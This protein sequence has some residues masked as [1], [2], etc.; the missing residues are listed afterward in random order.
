M[1]SKDKSEIGINLAI[2]MDAIL[3]QDSIP[4]D[5]ANTAIRFCVEMFK[6]YPELK[7][8]IDDMVQNDWDKKITWI[9][10]AKEFKLN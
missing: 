8:F 9:K 1:N 7:E 2:L 4:E 6:Q 10:W 3:N 5:V